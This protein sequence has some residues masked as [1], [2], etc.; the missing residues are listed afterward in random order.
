MLS[1]SGKFRQR[2]LTCDEVWGYRTA[3]SFTCNFMLL[4]KNKVVPVL[5]YRGIAPPFLTSALDGRWVVSS[6]P[7]PLYTERK[8]TGTHWIIRWVGL[9]AGLWAKEKSCPYWESNAGRLARSYTDS[10]ML[11]QINFLYA[12]GICLRILSVHNGGNG[13]GR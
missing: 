13:F 5:N 11:L 3:E 9:R 8:K 6:T 4:S 2:R 1:S 10:F 12:K 7:R